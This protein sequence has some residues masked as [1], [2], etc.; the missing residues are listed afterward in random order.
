MKGN[1]DG[2]HADEVEVVNIRLCDIAV[3]VLLPEQPGLDRLI[4]RSVLD[5]SGEVDLVNLNSKPSG[6]SQFPR[7]VPF[8]RNS[9]PSGPITDLPLTLMNLQF[10]AS[11]VILIKVKTSKSLCIFESTF[12][13]R[14]FKLTKYPRQWKEKAT[15]ACTCQ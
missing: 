5:E 12:L 9:R 7:F 6:T 4:R 2:I 3:G 8:I 13:K 10:C 1:A 15:K 14:K 11:A